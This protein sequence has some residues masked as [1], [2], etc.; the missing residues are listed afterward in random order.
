MSHR[1]AFKPNQPLAPVGSIQ[2]AIHS[3]ANGLEAK[4]LPLGALMLMGSLGAMAQTSTP[5]D[6]KTLK[7]IVIKESAVAPEGKDGL[8][9]TT[10]GIGK[11]NQALRDIP[12]SVTV[13]TEKLVDDRHLDT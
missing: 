3:V 13:V 9:A 4:H 7:P 5:A 6:T 2:S 12:Q 11:G 8:R 1:E 10:T